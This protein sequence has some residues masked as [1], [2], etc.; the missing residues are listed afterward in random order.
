MDQIQS[1]AKNPNQ[2]TAE[3]SARGLHDEN[4]RICGTSFKS[5]SRFEA[6]CNGCWADNEL[7]P[8]YQNFS[9]AFKPPVI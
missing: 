9:G 2:S 5:F 4:C 1:K 8:Y 7:K 6:I 3:L